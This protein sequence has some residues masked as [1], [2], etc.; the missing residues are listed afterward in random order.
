MLLS[1]KKKISDHKIENNFF[2]NFYK[3][4]ESN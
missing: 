4:M 3:K 2:L 1:K